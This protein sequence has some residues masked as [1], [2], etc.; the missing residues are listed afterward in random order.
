MPCQ[1][2]RI[3]AMP[4][5]ACLAQR[6][7]PGQEPQADPAK[8]CRALPS[9][10]CRPGRVKRSP[11]CPAQTYP[12]RHSR[13]DQSEP[14]LPSLATGN[15]NKPGPATPA[16]PCSDV[17]ATPTKP[18]PRLPSHAERPKPTIRAAPRMPCLPDR[19]L[20][21]RT[22]PHHPE[23]L[24]ACPVRLVLP[25]CPRQDHQAC[26]ALGCHPSET[27]VAQR[28]SAEPAASNRDTP[29]RAILALPATS[30]R[31]ENETHLPRPANRACPTKPG[32][33]AQICRVMPAM[34]A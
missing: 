28:S 5:Q 32:L 29:R 9:I 16:W 11:A 31:V 20:R 25:R 15:P 17:N 6:C 4:S 2:V 1:A 3:R 22:N 18:I 13:D 10:P 8:P 30:S 27:S 7:Y 21:C 14:C 24:R 12:D 23:P 26:L 33:S 19:D 34:Y